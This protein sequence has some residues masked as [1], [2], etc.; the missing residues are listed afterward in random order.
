[1]YRPFTRTPPFSSVSSLC[2]LLDNIA[3]LRTKTVAIQ[4]AHNVATYLFVEP[5]LREI[6]KAL[7][8]TRRLSIAFNR[9]NICT[10]PTG[11]KK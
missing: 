2:L 11:T 6:R 10:T 3:K 8:Y 1:M 4:Y 9:R 7:E 5:K